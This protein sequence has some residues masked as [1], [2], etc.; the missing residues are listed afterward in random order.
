MTSLSI[1]G[2]AKA[3][4]ATPVLRGVDLEVPAK[5]ITAILGPSGCGKTTLLRIIAGFTDPDGGV[6]KFGDQT[7][8]GA[9]RSV[10]PQRRRVGYVPQE[11]ALFPH[12]D[13]AANISFGLSRS[14]SRRAERIH[15]LLSLVGLDAAMGARFPHELSGGQQQRVA[16]A[17]ALAPSPAVVLLDEPFSSLDA[18]LR[19]G[20][21]RAVV[22]ALRATGATALLVTHDQ[23]EALSLSDQVAVMRQGRLAQTDRPL[24]LYRSPVDVGVAT[25]VGGAILLPATVRGLTARCALG[26]VAVAEGSA[27]GLGQ[28]L[29]RPEQLE[30]LPEGATG[31]VPARVAE[32]SFYGHDAAVHLDLL[33]HGP[34]VVARIVG[35]DAPPPATLVS[36]MARGRATVYATSPA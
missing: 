23:S 2:V 18:G 14:R 7:V 13:V 36:V 30:I 35:M 3:Y 19:E 33:P 34:R 15:E 28:V 8:Y 24:A 26:D 10:P 29:V 25:F 11:G 20:T 31:G 6:V 12:L 4:G 9:G 5:S 1:R 22:H 27:E 17:R 16:L 32:V 21:G